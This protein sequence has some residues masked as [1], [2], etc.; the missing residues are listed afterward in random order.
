MSVLIVRAAV[1]TEKAIWTV[2]ILIVSVTVYGLIITAKHCR[3]IGKV[4]VRG[5]FG[6]ECVAR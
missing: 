4:P 3:D 5:M 6:V 1:M 2:C